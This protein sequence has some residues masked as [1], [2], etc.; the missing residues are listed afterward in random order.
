MEIVYRYFCPESTSRTG[1][2]QLSHSHSVASLEFIGVQMEVII[3]NRQVLAVPCC[4][5]KGPLSPIRV[6][7]ILWI[8]PCHSCV[9]NHRSHE[10]LLGF[11]RRNAFWSTPKIHG[12]FKW[13]LHTKKDPWIF[14]YAR[15]SKVNAFSL[16]LP[17]CQLRPESR[18]ENPIKEVIRLLYIPTRL[19]SWHFSDSK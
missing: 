4:C 5:V 9:G 2:K 18:F 10:L 15:K 13:H 17:G 11:E 1:Q 8:W 7:Y 16:N 12:S 6:F 3:P 14:L 19:H